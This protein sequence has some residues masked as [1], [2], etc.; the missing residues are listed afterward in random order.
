MSRNVP[1]F[2][3]KKFSDRLIL[4][5]RLQVLK[6]RVSLYK[7]QEA[8]SFFKGKIHFSKKT[9]F[10]F[11]HIELFVLILKYMVVRITSLRWSLGS[12]KYNIRVPAIM[13]SLKC[14]LNF[15]NISLELK[16]V[17]KTSTTSPRIFFHEKYKI[18]FRFCYVFINT[19]C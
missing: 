9:T 17:S 1:F 6:K 14:N 10:W 16:G 5:T 19:R 15:I 13:I 12:Y 11:L 18:L 8:P 4:T 7:E 3:L 2:S